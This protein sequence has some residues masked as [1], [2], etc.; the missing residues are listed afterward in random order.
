MDTSLMDSMAWARTH[1]GAA[2]LGDRRREKRL[3]RVAA[4]LARKPQGTLPG[5]FDGWAE[6]KAAYRLL[7]QEAVTY[8][9]IIR[10]HWEYVRAGCREPGE[11]LLV[12]DNT[13]LDYTSHAAAEG[14]GFVGDGG[15]RGIMLHSTLA[16]RVER[17]E[18][19]SPRVSVMGLFAQK[20]WVRQHAP[21]RRHETKADRLARARESQV[22]GEALRDVPPPPEGVRQTYVADRE[23]DIYEVYQE[24]Q[25]QPR[26]STSFGPARR[27]RR[28]KPGAPSSRR[29]ARRP[30][31]A[32][33]AWICGP[34]RGRRP[35][36]LNWKC[37][38]AR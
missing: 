37:G 22:W 3:V 15:G 7:Q 28:T 5:S 31:W 29:W 20:P 1:F 36:R 11:Y 33:L 23:S 6:M 30:C 2:A 35:A 17:W 38:R 27:G 18:E 24:F 14:L 4:A 19:E 12:E 9:K 16:L 10:G 32:G 25:A 13:Q 21:R 8:E 34:G 26:A